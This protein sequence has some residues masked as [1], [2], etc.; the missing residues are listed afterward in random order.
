[1]VNRVGPTFVTRLVDE[2]GRDATDIARAYTV[3]RESFDL[4]DLWTAIEDLDLQV[5]AQTQIGLIHDAGRLVEW[6]TLWLLRRGSIPLDVSAAV[7]EL[8][9]AV[10]RLRESL[11]ELL[12]EE[13]REELLRRAGVYGEKGVPRELGLRVAGLEP[14]GAAFDVTR[15]ARGRRHGVEDVGRIYFHLGSR[16]QLE[17]LRT[18]AQQMAEEGPWA[19]AAVDGLV[20]HFFAYQRELTR[21]VLENGDAESGDEDVLERWLRTRRSPVSR[22]DR[23]LSELRE[24]ATPELSMLMVVDHQMRLLLEE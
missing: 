19:K 21:S 1:M 24:V 23:I 15:I 17:W 4:R 6:G 10:E 18:R 2:T 22:I 13:D 20:E 12:P 5:P 16:F 11:D 14:L 7:D 3:V 8:K 9:P